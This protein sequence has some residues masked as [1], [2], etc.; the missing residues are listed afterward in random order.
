VN[1][2]LITVSRRLQ[3]TIPRTFDSCKMAVKDYQKNWELLPWQKFPL[4]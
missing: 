4:P 3:Q 2:S 1:F